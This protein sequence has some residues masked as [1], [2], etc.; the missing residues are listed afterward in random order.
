[1]YTESDLES[2]ERD[3]LDQLV[4]GV[5]IILKLILRKYVMKLGTALDL[6]QKIKRAKL[7]FGCFVAH[8]FFFFWSRD[9]LS[10]SFS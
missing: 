8:S 7:H 3:C 1:M 10:Y 2:N 9:V 6:S 5:K 4:S